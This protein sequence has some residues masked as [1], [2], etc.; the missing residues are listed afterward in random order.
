MPTPS[1]WQAAMAAATLWMRDLES[2]GQYSGV[3]VDPTEMVRVGPWARR[4][5][6]HW[7]AENMPLIANSCTCASY[8]AP[9]ALLRAAVTA[10]L[11]F[12][13]P[14]IPTT[15]RASRGAAISW[16]EAEMQRLAG[17]SSTYL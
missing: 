7:R 14:Q 17:R 12:A 8:V 13:Q 6:G 15:V 1:Q 9:S 5:A 4:A 3:V 11:W 2:R 16:V 10:V